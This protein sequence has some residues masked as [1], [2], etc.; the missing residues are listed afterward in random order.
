MILVHE[1]G[2]AEDRPQGHGPGAAP[3]QDLPRLPRGVPT[4]VMNTSGLEGCLLGLALGDAMGAP[5]EGGPLE[6]MVW[7]LIGTTRDGDMRFTDDT[8]MSLDLG[9][10]L[11]AKGGVDEDDLAR[12]FAR[13]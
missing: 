4:E 6:R 11:I 12:R 7:R 9:E 13:S 1:E 10:S 8:Q 5:H 3:A 2:R